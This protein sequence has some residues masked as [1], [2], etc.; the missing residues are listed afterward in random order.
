MDTIQRVNLKN[1]IKAIHDEDIHNFFIDKINVI[2]MQSKND[3]FR[4][5]VDSKDRCK[6][7][8]FQKGDLIEY[9]VDTIDKYIIKSDDIPSVLFADMR[10]LTKEEQDS[11]YKALDNISI[12]TGI[13]LFPRS[14]NV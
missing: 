4:V 3:E 2:T 13:Q 12:D 5:V 9:I 8:V 7:I 1:Y 6:Y 10:N 11:L 14:K